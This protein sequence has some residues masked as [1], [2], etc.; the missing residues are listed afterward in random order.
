MNF[1]KLKNNFELF[2]DVRPA[3]D[4]Q[5]WLLN[6]HEFRR[7]RQKRR[8]LLQPFQTRPTR[9]PFLF[10]LARLCGTS[11]SVRLKHGIG[12][13]DQQMLRIQLLRKMDEENMDRRQRRR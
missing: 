1:W 11:C 13:R 9:D 7:Q 2:S 8:A 4:E 6:T 5:I 12:G 3:E 10:G